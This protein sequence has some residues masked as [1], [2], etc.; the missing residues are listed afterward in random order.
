MTNIEGPN[1]PSSLGVQ[2]D[3]VPSRQAAEVMVEPVVGGVWN[4]G[5]GGAHSLTPGHVLRFKWMILLI[6]LLVAI[7]SLVGIWMFTVPEY[8]V[9]GQIRIRPIIPRLVFKTDDNGPIQYYHSYLNTQVAIIVGPVV[10]QRVL[11][12]PEIQNTEWYR[13]QTFALFGKPPSPMERLKEGLVVQ[14]RGLTE[15]IDVTLTDP[16]P[17]DSALIVNAVLD[18]YLLFV[19]ESLDQT[20]DLMYK[21]LMEEY[22]SLRREIEGREKLAA[23]LRKD[24][25]TGTPEEL[26]SQ[27]RVRLDTMNSELETI[28]RSIATCEWQLKELASLKGGGEVADAAGATQPADFR[29]KNDQEWR[30]FY[31]DW[32]TLRYQVDVERDRLG[33]S[34]PKMIELVK[35]ADLAEEL[36]RDR[37]N[38]LETQIP[39]RSEMHQAVQANGPEL[40][41]DARF[42][43]QRI[44]Q[45]KYEQQLLVGD[46]EKE[47]AGFER[48]FD[49]AQMLA[50]E[51][52]TIKYK[53]ELYE[54]VRDRLNEKEMERNVPGSIDILANAMSPSEP[55]HDRRIILSVLAILGGVGVGGVLA[56]FR[57]STTQ[58]IYEAGDL[59][60]AACSPFLG[61]V[62]YCRRL[63]SGVETEPTEIGEYIR[64]I[65]TALLNRLDR[66]RSSVI[67]VTSACAGAGKST[68]AVMLAKSLTQCGKK[69]LLVDADLRKPSL[70]K[71]FD[72]DP[73]PGLH[74]SLMGL[75]RDDEAIIPVGDLPGLHV[76][77]AGIGWD[78]SDQ[79]LLGDGAF[80]RCLD[81]W[82]NE[83]DVIL[84]DGTPI[85]PVADA[86]ILCRQMDGTIL[87]TQR[88]HCRRSDVLDAMSC[89][90]TAGGTLLGTVFVGSGTRSSYYYYSGHKLDSSAEYSS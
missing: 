38:Y 36:M 46:V 12:L 28:R 72:L 26:V 40:F 6:F 24:L 4:R 42:L 85:L 35:K 70:A 68:V 87:V 61:Q 74:G 51:N 9:S 5:G 19:R 63:A 11:D 84:M 3:L 66:Q 52:E 56:F 37:Q 32:R 73:N 53:Q 49:T 82:R 7:P 60:H 81:R 8:D 13:K 41:Q 71:W 69:V 31:L 25:G 50:R 23:K 34:H 39:L 77:P 83:Y 20:D 17:N 67:L 18:Q 89:I 43:E 14:P 16:N 33:E 55:Q 57:A 30:K 65:R 1:E 29:Y 79:E 90:D 10:L 15:V 27:R 75:A 58:I 22:T 86:R 62:P 76:L 48:V 45:L 47:R 2:S 88:D 44:R 78:G 21:K 64:M 80:T 54:K 59:H